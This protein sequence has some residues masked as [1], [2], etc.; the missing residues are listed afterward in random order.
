MLV[1]LKAILVGLC[2][3]APLGPVVAFVI[4]RT[5]TGGRRAGL[6]A[7]AGSATVDTLYAA[8]AVFAL[9]VVQAFIDKNNLILMIGG[10]SLMIAIGLTMALK[11]PRRS[12]KSNEKI[13]KAKL[14]EHNFFPA[15]VLALSN[16]GA[17]MLMFGLMLAFKVDTDQDKLLTVAGVAIGAFGWWFFLTWITNKF[18]SRLK[19]R[20]LLLLNRLL[21]AAVA[22]FGVWM[23]VKGIMKIC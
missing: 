23:I 14:S 8:V 9:A 21:G 2:A 1:L 11:K 3:S 13:E 16:P 19:F 15:V 7:G 12:P 5:L 6:S 4:Q 17:I 18:G 22:V 10:G 20:G